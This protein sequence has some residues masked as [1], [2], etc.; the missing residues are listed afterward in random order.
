[1]SNLTLVV[2]PGP[3][4]RTVNLSEGMTVQNLV[5][6]E[7]LRGRDIIVNGQALSPSDYSTTVLSQ[8]M[9]IFATASVKG[10][11]DSVTLVIIPG[12]GAR[13]VVIRDGATVSDLVSTQNLQGRDIIINGQAVAPSTFDTTTLTP[14]DEVF[15]TASVKGN[16]KNGPSTTGRPSGSGR[17]NNPPRK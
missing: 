11:N 12:P 7:S 5:D 6:N 10:N 4:A 1:M 14:N 17:G 8:G 13:T 15:A 9:E 3:G 2:I 16:V